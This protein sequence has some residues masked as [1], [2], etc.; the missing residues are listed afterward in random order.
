VLL[1]PV[2]VGFPPAF[3]ER[4]QTVKPRARC[5]L[6]GGELLLPFLLE[7]GEDLRA[8][9][10]G[11]ATTPSSSPITRS[12]SWTVTPAQA[13]VTPPSHGT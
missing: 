3:A 9:P 11:S 4:V 1:D 12:P 2:L 13:T 6:G 10:G 8:S 7:G 5:H